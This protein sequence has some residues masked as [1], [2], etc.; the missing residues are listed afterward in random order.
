MNQNNKFGGRCPCLSGCS[1]PGVYAE[2]N[3]RCLNFQHPRRW[4]VISLFRFAS[5]YATS[6]SGRNFNWLEWSDAFEEFTASFQ[7][8]RGA[9][10]KFAGIRISRRLTQYEERCS[11]LCHFK[12]LTLPCLP[13]NRF[14]FS[15]W[16]PSNI[17]TMIVQTGVTKNELSLVGMINSYTRRNTLRVWQSSGGKIP[18][19]FAINPKKIVTRFMTYKLVWCVNTA[20]MKV[21]HRISFHHPICITIGMYR[22]GFYPFGFRTGID[23]HSDE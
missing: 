10:Y 12:W 7:V 8:E 1:D 17:D 5:A 20:G 4:D 15:A 23:I 6:P 11:V 2:Y 21:L 19:I 9:F 3:G 13:G 22:A 18:A 16:Y 14:E